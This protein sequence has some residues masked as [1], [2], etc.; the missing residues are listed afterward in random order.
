[1]AMSSRFRYSRS[2]ARRSR[3]TGSRGLSLRE[4]LKVGTRS[5][6]R[7]HEVAATVLLPARLV[8]FRADRLFLALADDGHSIGGDPEAHQI[9]L[10]RR[11]APLAASERV[12]RGPEWRE[13]DL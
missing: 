11:S 1:L 13:V 2:T 6:R 3:S 7:N 12:L 9:I 10:D 5:L 8:F 4:R